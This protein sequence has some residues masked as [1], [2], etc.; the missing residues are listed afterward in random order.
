MTTKATLRQA[1]EALGQGRPQKP[2]RRCRNCWQQPDHAQARWLLAQALDQQ[3]ESAG[4][5]EQLGLLL[6]FAGDKLGTIDQVAGYCCNTAT[7]CNRPAAYAPIPVGPAGLRDRRVQQPGTWQGRAVRG[8]L[9]G[10]LRA[11]ELGAHARR[12]CT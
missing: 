10:Y 12:K 9:A 7:R 4:A 2:P 1:A 6:R 8:R 11:L 5:I 3:G